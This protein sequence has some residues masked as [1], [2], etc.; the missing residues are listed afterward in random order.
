VRTDPAVGLTA[1]HVGALEAWA[2]AL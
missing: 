2:S 1:G